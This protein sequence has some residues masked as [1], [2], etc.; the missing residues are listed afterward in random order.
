MD[1]EQVVK[2]I[3]MRAAEMSVGSRPMMAEAS[4]DAQKQLVSVMD[5]VEKLWRQGKSVQRRTQT[6]LAPLIWQAQSGIEPEK[7]DIG[8]ATDMLDLMQPGYTPQW[9]RLLD[10][11]A[12]SLLGSMQMHQ[13]RMSKA[14]F[15]ASVQ[16]PFTALYIYMAARRF[17][18]PSVFEL[19]DSLAE[20]LILTDADKIKPSD[21]QLPLPGFY[22]Q[23]PPGALEM[24]NEATGWHKVTFVGIA[25]GYSN[26]S[27]RPGRVLMSVFWGEPNE[28]S[29]S[30][31]DDN[32]Q[33]S[34][35]SVPEEYDG[36][37]EQY[38]ATLR[39]Q[40]HI[41]N[42]QSFV[43]WNGTEF[44]FDDGHKLL[45]KFVVN[46]CLYLSSPNPDI[47]PTGGK[48]TW[49]DVVDKAEDARKAGPYAKR[50]VTVGKN[51]SLWDVGRRV[52][53][54][55][56]TMTATDIL[57]RGHWRRQVHGPR[58]S[59]RQVIWIEPF[60]RRP[61]GGDVEGHEYA[62]EDRNLKPN[63][64]EHEIARKLAAAMTPALGSQMAREVSN[65]AAIALGDEGNEEPA[66]VIVSEMLRYRLQH[67]Q[68]GILKTDRERE[69][70]MESIDAALTAIEDL[71]LP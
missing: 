4:R 70:T 56:R 3:R 49:K 50:P 27:I 12:I 31:T 20:K 32:A 69:L 59:L 23:M 61:T 7:L 62:V 8:T 5:E 63:A 13:G 40:E 45:R 54:L 55:Q 39:D 44:S 43:R 33:V 35:I 71:E 48:Q 11:A 52:N 9:S 53:R 16:L 38:E 68:A 66:V 37:I 64:N 28:R 22:I 1:F 6:V 21:V 14:Q 15:L 26:E 29:T 17:G 67:P 58:W 30:A 60:V 25:E 34:F 2:V 47:Q 19:R 51:F 10:I 36:S 18:A 41:T 57:V 46:F 42:R 24:W 65:N